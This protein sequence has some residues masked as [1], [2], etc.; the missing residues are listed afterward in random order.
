MKFTCIYKDECIDGTLVKIHYKLKQDFKIEFPNATYNSDLKMW[1]IDN[2]DLDKFYNFEH[3][4]YQSIKDEEFQK[5][6]N[7]V[8]DLNISEQDEMILRKLHIY[9]EMLRYDCNNQL[10]HNLR[11]IRD[12][13][14]KSR[15]SKIVG[16]CERFKRQVHR[17][18]ND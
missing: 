2:G 5:Y 18:Y 13:N 14:E 4:I 7:L 15:L 6:Y 17:I 9:N 1:I 3:S 16:I 11:H 12:P 10:A 8:L